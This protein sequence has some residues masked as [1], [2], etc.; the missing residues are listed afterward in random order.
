MRVMDENS[1]LHIHGD[2]EYNNLIARLSFSRMLKWHVK[3]TAVRM[4][5]AH[6]SVHLMQT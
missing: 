6:G 1:W 4:G 2:Q 5:W 3:W